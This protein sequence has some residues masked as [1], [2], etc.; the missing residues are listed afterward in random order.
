MQNPK[1]EVNIELIPKRRN[2]LEKLKAQGMIK[3]SISLWA[4]PVVIVEK[5]GGDLQMCIDYRPLNKVTKPD[6]YPLSR[7]DN[8]L[9][10]FRTANWFS[11]LD[12]ASGF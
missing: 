9:E 5:K 8:L 12:L 10:S 4:A 1:L 6:I 11:T 3:H 7:I 2:F